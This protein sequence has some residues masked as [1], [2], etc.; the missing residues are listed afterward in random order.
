M[1][2]R[3]ASP[4]IKVRVPRAM[5]HRSST[6]YGSYQGFL[7][8][9][10]TRLGTLELQNGSLR[11]EKILNVNDGAQNTS[12]FFASLHLHSGYQTFSLRKNLFVH[13]FPKD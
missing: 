7:C 11:S 1:L 9:L 12:K 3:Q 6:N 2:G 5:R 10:G 8:V 13:I 4:E